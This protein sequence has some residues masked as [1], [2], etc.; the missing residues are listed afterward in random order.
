MPYGRF[1]VE[2]VRGWMDGIEA[3]TKYL[4]LVSAD[5]GGSTDPLTV[6]I[7][8]GTLARQTSIWLRTGPTA[9]TLE[10]PVLFPGIPPGGHVAGVAGFDA[11]FNGTMLFYDLFD[12][13]IDYPSGGT[14]L[15]PGGE[16]VLGVDIPNA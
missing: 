9:L 4:T 14:F 3:K 7:V 16:Y 13:A 1:G 8:G 11:A 15:L 2:I 5:P 6:E 12:V 10:V